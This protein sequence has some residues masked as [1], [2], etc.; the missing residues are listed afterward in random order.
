[1]YTNIEL[2]RTFTVDDIVKYYDIE[3]IGSA[4]NLEIHIFQTFTEDSVTDTVEWVA[5]DCGLYNVFVPYYPMLTTD[6]YAG[7]QV[8]AAPATF[9]QEEPTEGV[10]YPTAACTK[11]SADTAAA[12]HAAAVTLVN[13]LIAE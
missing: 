4:S 11:I 10:Y 8:S 2:G 9:S 12:V 7:Y 5:M 1:M 6:T 13:G 3:G